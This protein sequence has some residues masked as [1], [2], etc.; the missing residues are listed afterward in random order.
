MALI[1]FLL[2]IL[3]NHEGNDKMQKHFTCLHIII[4]L[5]QIL[6][7][8]NKSI[9]RACLVKSASFRIFGRTVQII[10]LTLSSRLSLMK[11]RISLK[12]ES[13]VT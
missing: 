2:T 9:N 13:S 6:D 3:F 10:A 12:V 7:G 8:L 4:T 5:F 1:E 11:R